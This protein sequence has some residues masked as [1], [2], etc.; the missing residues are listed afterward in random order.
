MSQEP[1]IAPAAQTEPT[2][3]PS[4]KPLARRVPRRLWAW[5]AAITAAV[6]LVGGGVL[7]YSRIF[8]QVP[9]LPDPA[10][11]R[12]S[13]PAFCRLVKEGIRTDGTT[14]EEPILWSAVYLGKR[15]GFVGAV[16]FDLPDPVA[17]DGQTILMC[18]SYTQPANGEVWQT[19]PVGTRV[20]F[21]AEWNGMYT[22]D[23][24]GTGKHWIIL[25]NVKL[26]ERQ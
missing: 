1:S 16:S 9:E 13:Y 2:T 15:E 23:I 5:L 7:I 6:L 4:N 12:T 21:S 17:P 19:V 11:W 10:K 24:L 26:V 20:L 8:K 3:N 14:P 25:K 22:I 18:Y